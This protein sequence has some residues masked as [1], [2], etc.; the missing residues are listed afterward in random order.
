MRTIIVIA[1]FL[2]LGGAIGFTG[3]WLEFSV[4]D[5][6]LFGLP[7]ITAGK[8]SS[9]EKLKEFGFTIPNEAHF[10]PHPTARVIGGELFDFGTM[11]TNSTRSHK[12]VIRNDGDADLAL[13]KGSTSCKCTT[14]EVDKKAI[15]PGESREVT[16]EWKTK[17]HET[18]FSQF[19]DLYT[20]DPDR[21][22]IRLVVS[23][24]V[25]R[26]FRT[27]PA[28]IIFGN[29]SASESIEETAS[30]YSFREGK[31]NIKEVVLQ[32]DSHQ[33][34]FTI[35]WSEMPKHEVLAGDKAKAGWKIVVKNKPGMQMG[36]ID[37]A[38]KVVFDDP[39]ITPIE[40]PI[41]A[42]ITSDIVLS[43]P[44]LSADRSS[45]E[46]GNIDSNVGKKITAYILVKGE[47]RDKVE[48]ELG[49]VTP[50]ES[51]RASIGTPT[52]GHSKNARWPITIEVPVGAK[53]V[54]CLGGVTGRNGRI[55]I[56]CKN[57]DRQE[58]SLKVAFAVDDDSIK[59]LA[60]PE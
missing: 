55:H 20:N 4:T 2:G 51:L 11:E 57:A 53:P 36:M 9:D 56:L 45:F 14:S 47:N 60:T 27:S 58:F 24:K 46:L 43:G 39:D 15:K 19:A 41:R 1:I 3:T 23:G 5:S 29:I 26:S 8:D 22:T 33:D 31:I 32:G 6:A 34:D 13:V 21:R 38:V 10:G 7:R 59:D 28:E 52:R 12:F 42:Q 35:T 49:N 16:L 37:Q 50:G 17:T 40:L 18:T 25:T 44:N 30:I 48:L 54:N